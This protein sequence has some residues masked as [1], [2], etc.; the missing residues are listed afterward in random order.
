M[1]LEAP[2][3]VIGRGVM[4]ARRAQ[5]T[6]RADPDIETAESVE[7]LVYKDNRFLLLGD[8]ERVGDDLRLRVVVGYRL[9]QVLIRIRACCP[10]AGWNAML[11]RDTMTLVAKS[12]RG[13]RAVYRS[14]A[15]SR[16]L[17]D[18]GLTYGL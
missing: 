14:C 15:M 4:N 11:E 17:V 6:R 1:R 2:L 10:I 9:N 13:R 8:V 18:D 7:N 12:S 3:Q 5:E 16:Q